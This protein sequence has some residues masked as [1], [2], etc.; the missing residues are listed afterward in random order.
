MCVWEKEGHVV[1]NY[2]IIRGASDVRVTLA[3]KTTF[4]AKNVGFEQD[5]DVVVLHIDVP[6]D[7]LR[8]IHVGI[9]AYLLIGR[10]GSFQ[11]L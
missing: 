9:S 11:F 5:K 8:L 3:H 4:D 2:H 6:K 1:T 10:I 7:K